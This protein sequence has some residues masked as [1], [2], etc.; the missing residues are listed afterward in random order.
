M[1]RWKNL[2]SGSDFAIT[3]YVI[4]GQSFSHLFLYL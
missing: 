2:G 4:L 1:S 3:Y